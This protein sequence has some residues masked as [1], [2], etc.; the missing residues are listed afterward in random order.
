MDRR[1][2]LLGRRRGLVDVVSPGVVV[3][4]PGAIRVLGGMPMASVAVIRG[5]SR[6]RG[7]RHRQGR[8]GHPSQRRRQAE[9]NHRRQHAAHRQLDVP[10]QAQAS[11]LPRGCALIGGPLPMS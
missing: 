2:H 3:A 7:V 8:K 11:G 4:V 6:H 10:P 9:G 5:G 1:D